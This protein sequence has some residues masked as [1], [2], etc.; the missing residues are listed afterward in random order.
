MVSPTGD[1]MR[2]VRY[3]LCVKYTAPVLAWGVDIIS[4][5]TLV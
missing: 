2:S 3:L 1:L 4:S 5:L